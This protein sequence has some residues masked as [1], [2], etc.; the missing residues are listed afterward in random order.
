MDN[1]ESKR[2]DVDVNLLL[3]LKR[4]PKGD[5]AIEYQEIGSSSWKDLRLS[6]KIAGSKEELSGTFQ[7]ALPSGHSTLRL[8]LTPGM[9]PTDSGQSIGITARLSRARKSLDTANGSAPLTNFRVEKKSGSEYVQRKGDWSEYDFLVNNLSAVNYP[10]VQVLAFMCEEVEGDCTE[11]ES[12]STLSLQWKTA[13]GWRDLK[14]PSPGPAPTS[15]AVRDL[16]DDAAL[17]SEIPLPHA[18]SKLLNF[19]IKETGNLRK[20]PWKGQLQLLARHKGDESTTALSSKGI[21]FEIK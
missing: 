18:A 9:R 19:R 4:A 11:N 12:T 20:G 1:D 2:I 7:A 16:E 21:T 15:D 8:R 6:P 17:V 3:S 14:I 10:K 13:D 5:V